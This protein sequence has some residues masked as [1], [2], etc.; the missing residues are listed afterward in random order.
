MRR[1]SS[2]SSVQDPGRRRSIQDRA[3]LSC[4][5]SARLRHNVGLKLCSYTAYTVHI[6]C[7]SVRS[8]NPEKHPCKRKGNTSTSGSLTIGR[9]YSLSSTHSSH[10]PFPDAET[11]KPSRRNA[12]PAGRAPGHVARVLG[13]GSMR[14]ALRR[15]GVAS[16]RR[17]TSAALGRPGCTGCPKELVLKQS[18]RSI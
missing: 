18:G 10:H 13:E 4:P 11:Q 5:A 15:S 9:S 7:C 1:E 12:R 6:C 3:S 17:S 8:Q 16:I 2:Q 14:H